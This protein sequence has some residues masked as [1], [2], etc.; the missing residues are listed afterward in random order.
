MFV[1]K[2]TMQIKV[3]QIIESNWFFFFCWGLKDSQDI[4]G[5]PSDSDAWE[6][7]DKIKFYYFIQNAIFLAV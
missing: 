7:A 1:G 4:G 6:T 3:P 2:C 5:S